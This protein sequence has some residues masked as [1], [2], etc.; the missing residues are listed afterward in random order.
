MKNM[1]ELRIEVEALAVSLASGY[2]AETRDRD[3]IET[4][5]NQLWALVQSAMEVQQQICGGHKNV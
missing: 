3:L 1:G 5:E 4:L 2:D